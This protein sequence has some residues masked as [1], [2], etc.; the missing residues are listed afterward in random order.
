MIALDK[1]A[2]YYTPSWSPD[3]KKLL[4]TDTNLHVW[5]LDV[6]SGK[7]KIVGGDPWMVP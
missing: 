6:E 2:H 5:V 4:F 1:P 7:A 3:S